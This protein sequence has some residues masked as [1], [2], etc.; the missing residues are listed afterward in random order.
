MPKVR[1]LTGQRF[2]RLVV[3][4]MRPVPRPGRTLCLCLCDCG[5][6]TEVRANDIV[7][8]RSTSCGCYRAE[9]QTKHGDVKTRLHQ[10]WVNMKS[11]CLRPTAAGY[12]NYGG[13]GISICQEWLEDYRNFKKDMG[14]TYKP[15]LTL[16]RIDNNKGY[17]KENCRWATMKEQGRNRRTNRYVQTPAGTMVMVEAATLY[18]LT[19]STIAMRIKAGLSQEETF[20]PSSQSK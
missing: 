9:L 15:H 5:I 2:G 6:T 4:E 18:N 3:M 10:V 19:T 1:D 13:R 14:E 8:G 16:E 7:G 11:R 12:G 17:Y 20:K